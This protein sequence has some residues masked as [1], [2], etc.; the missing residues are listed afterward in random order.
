MNI[1]Q[2]LIPIIS[3]CGNAAEAWTAL[4]DKFD[5]KNA[6]SL[7]TLIKAITTL[8]YDEKSSLSDHLSTFDNLWTR[9][10]ERTCAATSTQR[11]DFALKS[12]ADSDEAKGAFLLLSLPKAYDN[13]VDNLQ[14]K[15]NLTYND[16]YQ[17]LMD[18]ASTSNQGSLDNTAYKVK[19]DKPPKECSWC[20]KQGYFYKGH[21]WKNCRKLKAFKEKEKKKDDKG[22]L[23]TTSE[24]T[25]F[26]ANVTPSSCHHNWVFDTGATTHMTANKAV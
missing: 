8:T 15:E 14:T 3:S 19:M 20:Q 2:G 24:A 12:L 9:L 11:L 25:A 5:R 21:V 10:K 13:I 4:A 23:A 7:H 22:N 6:I 18:L 16:I 17:R 26:L 1:D